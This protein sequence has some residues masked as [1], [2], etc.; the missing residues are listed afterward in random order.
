MFE[1]REER[2]GAFAVWI[3]GGERLAVLRTEAAAHA[4]VDALEDA[5]DDAFLRAVSEVQEDYA[6]DFIDP[7][8][9]A[10]N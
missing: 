7:M 1:V 5:W 3:A 2:D 6:A 4:L 8:P 10:T 9:P